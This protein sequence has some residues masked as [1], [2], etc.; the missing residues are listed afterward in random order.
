VM[1]NG[2]RV[3]RRIWTRADPYAIRGVQRVYRDGMRLFWWYGMFLSISSAFV[4]SF[5]T[6]Y[7][8]SLGA[9]R[10]QVGLL[11]SLASFFGMLMPIPGAQW[12]THW[13]KRKPV[14]VISYG[15]RYVALF[16]ALLVPQFGAGPMVVLIVIG[17]FA[18]RAA[19]LHL[20]N[21]PWTSF[22]GDIVPAERRGRYF[23][24]RKT[25]MALASLIFV[26]LAGQFI[27]LFP[28]PLGYRISFAVAVVWGLFSL[29]LFARIPERQ[30]SAPEP[31]HKL[32][33][34]FWTILKQDTTFWRF[35]LI[36]MIFHFAWHMS[37]PYFG[38]YEVEILG[39]TARII[40]WLSMASSFMRMVGQQVWG[41]AT[42]RRGSAWAFSLCLLFIPILPFIWLPLTA[43]WQLIFVVVPSGF[44]WAGYEI[45]NFNLLLELADKERQTE[46]IA[47][48]H[49]LLAMANIL[50]P[51]VGGQLVQTFGYRWTFAVSGAGRMVAALLFVMLLR[52]FDWPRFI[53]R[54]RTRV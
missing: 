36:A 33:L 1:M 52:P 11:A 16:G 21:S 7:V 6:L 31:E 38:V 49:T 35:T 4:D 54:F 26:P 15:L 53:Q 39:A 22:A 3:L 9:T 40:G 25:V 28:E 32:N 41:R 19:F 18:L 23:S 43:P 20:G 24:S 8:L 42:D 30:E 51:L 47:S 45:A 12:A 27:G 14:V 5:I 37:T 17:L 2:R 34:A 48:Y 50:G 46:A 29:V 44:L 10:V 13:G